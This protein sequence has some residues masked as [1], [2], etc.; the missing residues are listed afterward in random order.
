MELPAPF[1]SELGIDSSGIPTIVKTALI[2]EFITVQ[3]AFVIPFKG[4]IL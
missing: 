3:R 2:T 1:S 4:R